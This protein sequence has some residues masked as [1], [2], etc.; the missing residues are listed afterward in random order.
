MVPCRR[1]LFE[2]KGGKVDSVEGLIGTL[3]FA[4]KKHDKGT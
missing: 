4:E 1:K 3:E 2:G